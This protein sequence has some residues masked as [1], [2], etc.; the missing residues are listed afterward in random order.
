MT[1]AECQAEIAR[2]QCLVMQ[3]AERLAAA[4][5]VLSHV[6]ERRTKPIK[7]FS[8]EPESG[9]DDNARPKP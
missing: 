6:A 3:L 2:L 1:D 8:Q 5:E 7:Q 9:S 4:S